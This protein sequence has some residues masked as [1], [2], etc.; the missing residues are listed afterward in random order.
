M[1][2]LHLACKKKNF[3]LAKVYIDHTSE[4]SKIDKFINKKGKNALHAVA[5]QKVALETLQY[6]IMSKK[7]T[8]NFQEISGNTALYISFQEGVTSNA[9]YLLSLININCKGTWLNNKGHSPLYLATK[10]WQF[11]FIKSIVMKCNTNMLLC[12]VVKLIILIEDFLTY[13]QLQKM[14]NY[15]LFSICSIR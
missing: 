6:M 4:C 13:T 9:E 11:E 2:T 15:P 12:H 1:K 8:S 10:E 3:A 7:F 14:L 5:G